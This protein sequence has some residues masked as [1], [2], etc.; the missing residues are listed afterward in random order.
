MPRRRRHRF[1]GPHP[2]ELIAWDNADN[3]IWNSYTTY[4]KNYT[5]DNLPAG[6]YS[7][8]VTDAMGCELMKNNIP[9][10]N[11]GNVLNATFSTTAAPCG[12]NFGWINIDVAN[13]SPPYWITVKGPMSGTV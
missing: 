9:I 1:S 2:E 12:S 10:T 11:A 8:K 13:S 5:I 4:D 6:I 7:V 3:S